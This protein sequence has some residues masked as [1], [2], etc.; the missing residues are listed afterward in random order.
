MRP[1]PVF[2][3]GQYFGYEEQV[4][5]QIGL[6]GEEELFTG[7]K[8][9]VF[10]NP[11]DRSA[12]ISFELQKPESVEIRLINSVGT[13]VYTSGKLNYSAGQH[14]YELERKQLNDGIYYLQMMIGEEI[15]VEKIIVK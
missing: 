8:M 6:T 11:F 7:S 12:T 3:Q 2:W 13:Q 9:E 5:F 14:V 4:Q 15:A 10:P 1:H